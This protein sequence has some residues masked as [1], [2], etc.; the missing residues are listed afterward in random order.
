MESE[1]DN[2]L[3]VALDELTLNHPD[4]RDLL[5]FASVLA[6]RPIPF[7]LL[8]KGQRYLPAD[9]V[10]SLQNGLE[11]VLAPLASHGFVSVNESERTFLVQRRIQK[12]L[13]KALPRDFTQQIQKAALFSVMAAIHG[14]DPENT[15][16]WQTI[17]P[18]LIAITSATQDDAN[19]ARVLSEAGYVLQQMGEHE[20]SAE[21]YAK[22]LAIY[23]SV[24]PLN[25]ETV[26]ICLHNLARQLHLQGFLK[27]AR[28][29]Y[30]RELVIRRNA[31]GA[32]HPAV[33][34]KLSNLGR[35]LIDL[36]EWTDARRLYE[37]VLGIQEKHLSRDDVD[38][39]HTRNQL[40][41]ILIAQ[42]ELGAAKA[43][44][45]QA[46]AG[47]KRAFGLEHTSTAAVLNNL[48]TI[49]RRQGDLETATNLR[50]QVLQ[51]LESLGQDDP[52]MS[53]SLNN[54]G[55]LL[56]EQGDPNSA[57]PLYRRALEILLATVP[58]FHP[59]VTL[60]RRNLGFLCRQLGFEQEAKFLYDSAQAGEAEFNRR[61]G[62]DIQQAL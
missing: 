18:H 47:C 12:A 9:L 21:M 16:L 36:E 20:Q 34:E 59:S 51:I 35:L 58:D 13:S 8:E 26:A 10:A 53:A 37:E 32:E 49:A 3:L 29:L 42:G 6:P 48:A 33:L 50:K 2:Q 5:T 25:N 7:E 4:L 14:F 52:E 39:I 45:D 43:Y 56:V 44:L 31:L 23:E 1:N 55:F 57:L 11:K 28:P 22:S 46:M 19:K 54:F 30:E 27:S 60:Q 38:T 41:S 61:N 62:S 24:R 40:A 17:Y 15:S